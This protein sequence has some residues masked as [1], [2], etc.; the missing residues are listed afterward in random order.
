MRYNDAGIEGDH[1]FFPSA[2]GRAGFSDLFKADENEALR[3][4]HRLEMRAS[5]YL[6]RYWRHHDG[7]RARPAKVPLPRGVVPLWGDENVYRWSRGVL[8]SHVLGSMYLALDEWIVAQASAGRS[9]EE[10]ANLVL[11]H[12]GLIGTV[13]PLISAL[14][15]N[16]N[17]RSQIDAAGPFLATPRLWNYD[18]R[19]YQDEIQRHAIGWMRRDRFFDGAEKIAQRYAKQQFLANELLLPFQLMSGS[20]AREDLQSHRSTWGPADL[21]AF[22][23]ELDNPANVAEFERQIEK[24]RSDTDP[25]RIKLAADVE[26]GKVIVSITPSEKEETE[27]ERAS[28]TQEKMQSVMR[29]WNWV[30]KS[31][32]LSTPAPSLTIVEAIGLAKELAACQQD[33]DMDAFLWGNM[34]VGAVVGTAS[35]AVRFGRD[36]EIRK[37]ARWIETQLITGANFRRNDQEEQFLIDDVSMSTDPRLYSAEGL[38]ALV[39]RHPHNKIYRTEAVKFATCR[40]SD[41]AASVVSNIN[42]RSA[43]NT[44]WTCL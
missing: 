40:F 11:Q 28:E 39:N 29:L 24:L 7:R 15:L 21:A 36:E 32:D 17:D 31:R 22:D 6:R 5:V 34:R 3:L 38:V 25:S 1:G 4:F 37:Y 20:A 16:A 8:G 14:A 18:I 2:P 41:I 12:N 23:D 10:L 19:R 43:P 27:R 35:I 44:A 33:Q 9:I 13:V 42:W 30:M 26:P